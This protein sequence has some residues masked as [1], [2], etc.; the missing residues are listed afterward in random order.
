MLLRAVSAERDLE[1]QHSC[2]TPKTEASDLT[3][4]GEQECPRLREVQVDRT[5]GEDR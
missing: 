3:V 4:S 5:V 1:L 2:P